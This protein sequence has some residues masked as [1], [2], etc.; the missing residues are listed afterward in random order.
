M[1]RFNPQSILLTFS[2]A[3]LSSSLQAQQQAALPYAL[4]SKYMDLFQSLE[5]LDRIVSEL[6]VVSTNPDI[7]PQSIEFKIR[8][9]DKW[10]TFHPNETGVIQF[11]REPDWA[12]LTFISNQPKG[13]LQLGVSF[14]AV[15]LTSTET[16][17]QELMGLVPQFR[18]ALVALADL[19]GIPAPE[20]TGLT[21]QLPQ[22][23]DASVRIGSPKGQRTVKSYATGIVSLRYDEAL[24]EDNP[25]VEFD[26]LP[27]GIIPLQ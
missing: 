6:L 26:Q 22:G 17:Y 2:L 9:V 5:H 21:I 8:V 14:S 12:N 13:T 27:I 23:S 24:W 20:V 11:P 25:T 10:Q 4:A 3:F 1:I 18:E 19:Q 7:K 16:S 15:P